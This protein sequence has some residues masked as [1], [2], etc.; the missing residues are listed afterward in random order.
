MQNT[1]NRYLI[2]LT[3]DESDKIKEVFSPSDIF[4]SQ[5]NLAFFESAMFYGWNPDRRM[6]IVPLYLSSERVI[7]SLFTVDYRCLPNELTDMLK[8]EIIR[9]SG[10]TPT[11]FS[12]LMS[13]AE[14]K[15]GDPPEGRT[16]AILY[17]GNPII[18]EINGKEFIVEVKG[19]GSPDGDNTRTRPMIRYGYF[20]QSVTRYGSVTRSQ[21]EREFKNLEFQ[22]NKGS[23]TFIS[24]ES[25]RAAALFIYVNDVEYGYDFQREDQAYLL[26]LSPGNIRSSYNQNPNFPKLK[27][28][29]KILTSS[30]AKHYA[31]LA[32]LEGMLL[33]STIHPENILR[34]G[35]G[36][37][38]TDFADCRRLDQIDDPHNFLSDVLDII[39]EVPGIGEN[40][41][42]NFYSTLAQELGVQWDRSTGYNGFI[43]AIWSG[44]FAQRVYDIRK[45]QDKHAQ[46]QIKSGKSLLEPYIQEDKPISD[47]FINGVK[48]F[49]EKEIDLLQYVNTPEAKQSLRIAGER[50]AYLNSQLIDSTDINNRFKQ[51]SESFFQLLKLPY[52]SQ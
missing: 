48:N 1:N 44:F 42:D 2:G 10:N 6:Q 19:V 18:V 29:G 4:R 39:K 15:V 30:I 26:R 3:R 49:L 38:L 32:K 41:A 27:N 52:M 25:P 43:E 31:E 40:A 51:D 24:G 8:R 46:K 22:R 9:T 50:V 36:Y 20:G 28:R 47:F 7:K 13:V 23:K 37:V 35:S 5:R 45:G 12:V 14:S 21:G 11:K 16:G 34:T 33:H 17:N